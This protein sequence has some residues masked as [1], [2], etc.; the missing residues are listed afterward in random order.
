MSPFQPL[1]YV[2]GLGIFGA[3]ACA[4]AII[5]ASRAWR[6]DPAIALRHD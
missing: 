4:A 5:A 1:T 2:T 6:I 3:A